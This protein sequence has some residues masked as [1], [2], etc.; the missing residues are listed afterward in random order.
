MKAKKRKKDDDFPITQPSM[1]DVYLGEIQDTPL[2]SAEEEIALAHQIANGDPE[3][4]KQ[5]IVANLRL[6][7]NIAREFTGKGLHLQDLIEEGNLGLIRAADK[8]DPNSGN[9]FSTYASYWIKQAIRRALINTSKSIRLPAYMVEILSRWRRATPKLEEDLR[10]PPM[11]QEIARRI[12]IS[13]AKLPLVLKALGVH[14][15]CPQLENDEDPNDIAG[16]PDFREMNPEEACQRKYLRQQVFQELDSLSDKEQEVL[17]M[18]YGLDGYD[19]HTLKEVGKKLHLTRER[20]R[21]II[22]TAL[23]KIGQKVR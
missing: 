19:I 13:P 15:L 3:A 1:M 9:R 8:F 10:R 22:K 18:R 7:V 12:G 14:T 23:Q 5:M 21:Q 16:T 11:C 4:R 6:V 20:V 17:R 2:L